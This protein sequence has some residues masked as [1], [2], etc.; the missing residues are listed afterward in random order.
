MK[1]D[2]MHPAKRM[3]VEFIIEKLPQL[4]QRRGGSMPKD[5][6]HNEIQSV[7]RK[8]HGWP[9]ALDEL[10]SLGEVRGRKRS[11]NAWGWAMRRLNE[12]GTTKPCTRTKTYELRAK[13][14]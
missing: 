10:E 4:L 13:N 12:T 9:P 3:L 7:F 1:F 14:R 8:A 5:A 11:S 6:A 2:E